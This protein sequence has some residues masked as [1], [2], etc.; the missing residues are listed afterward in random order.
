[1]RRPKLITSEW[2]YNDRGNLD[3]LL[4]SRRF[5]EDQYREAVEDDNLGSLFYVVYRGRRSS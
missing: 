2:L 3:R 5:P 1:V 4:I